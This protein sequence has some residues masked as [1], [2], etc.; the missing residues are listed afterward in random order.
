MVAA[1]LLPALPAAAEEPPTPD[2]VVTSEPTAEPT[3]DPTTEPTPESTP[4][5]DPTPTPTPTSTQPSDSTATVTYTG[6]AQQFS[7][8][9]I[10][11][12]T[13]VVQ[14]E[15][16]GQGF[17]TVDLSGIAKRV[18]ALNPVT[19][20][21]AVPAGLTLS[22][23]AAKRFTQ[24]ATASGQSPLVA[25]RTGKIKQPT[26][27]DATAQLVN[28]TPNVSATHH[29][30]AVY[31][32]PSNKPTKD[33]D[34]ATNGP[35]QDLVDYADQYWSKQSGGS[36]HFTLDGVVPWYK[37]DY[38]CKTQS[39]SAS[40]WSQALTKAKS[41]GY[42]PGRN[43][44]LV[45]IFPD[46]TSFNYTYCGGAI[47]LGTIGGSVNQGGQTWVMGTTD[48]IAFE[49]IAHELGH[50]MSL[51]HADWLACPSATPNTSIDAANLWTA[52]ARGS[53]DL[54]TK[55]N[56]G[57]I[58][59]VM[60][61][62]MGDGIGGPLSAPQAIRAGIWPSGSYIN[63]P[64]GT[65]TYTLTALSSYTGTRGIVVQD[66]DGTSYFLEMRNLAGDDAT[67]HQSCPSQYCHLSQPN[68]RMLRFEP[69]GY[70]G[71]PGEDSFLIGRSNT[72][73]G[74]TAAS[75]VYTLPK[76]NTVQINS[77]GSTTAS[78][79]VQRLAPSTEV[80]NDWV[81]LSRTLGYDSKLRVGD[82]LTLLIGDYYNLE[83]ADY[84]FVWT[85]D[86]SSSGMPTTQNYTLKPADVGHRINAYLLADGNQVF[87]L[88]GNGNPITTGY[89]ISKGI[90]QPSDPGPVT[91]NFTNT[92]FTVSTPLG[93]G[94]NW[95]NG[96]EFT[97]QWMRGATDTTATT[98]STGA[99]AT[100]TSYTPNA[101]DWNQFLRVKVTATVPGYEP[102]VRYSTPAINKSIYTQ[103]PLPVE[104]TIAG[105]PKIG[106][107]VSV[108]TST[109]AYFDFGGSSLSGVTLEYQWLRNGVPITDTP[110]TTLDA[111]DDAD[112]TLRSL[113]YNASIT[114]RVTASKNGYV[115]KIFSTA[116]FKPTQ[117][118]TIQTAGPAAAI[119]NSFDAAA[120]MKVALTASYTGVTEP[121]L[122]TPGY[123]WYRV[124]LTSGVATAISG[125]TGSVY[126]PVAGDYPYKIRVI[127][128]IKKKNYASLPLTYTHDFSI[129]IDPATPLGFIGNPRVDDLIGVTDPDM[130]VTLLNDVQNTVHFG[131]PGVSVL[132]QWRRSGVNIPNETDS[133]YEPVA[134]DV[135][136]SLSY[137][138]KIG[139]QG[140]IGFTA[141]SPNSDVTAQALFSH[142]QDV[143]LTGTGL[144]KTA[145][146]NAND[147]APYFPDTKITYQW[148]RDGANISGETKSTYLLTSADYGHSVKV[149][150]SYSRPGY[151]TFVQYGE[152]QTGKFWVRANPIRP[153]LTG[154]HTVGST[155]TFDPSSVTY[156]T[157]LNGATLSNPSDM[158]WAYQW[159][160]DG[161][162]IT[163]QISASYVVK[164]SD[165][166][167]T[168][169]LKVT[170]SSPTY[171][172]LLPSVSTSAAIAMVGTSELPG[173]ST[174]DP[175]LV[176]L[177]SSTASK[178]V[179]GFT[180]AVGDG[181][182][183]I[184]SP[185]GATNTVKYQWLRN[186]VAITGAT[187]STYTL[188]TS[189]RGK[190]I[191]LRITTSHAAIGPTSYT[192]D[193]RYSNEHDFS[194]LPDPVNPPRLYGGAWTVGTFIGLADVNF[195]DSSGTPV[196]PDAIKVEWLRTINGTTTL[197]STGT[198]QSYTLVAADYG[199]TMSARLTA[200]EP[201]FVPVTYTTATLN[202]TV[203]KGTDDDAWTPEVQDGPGLGQL[204]AA[205]TNLGPATPA[206]TLTY[207]WLR[208]G[209]AISGATGK[210]YT[211]VT[212]DATKDIS[213][214]VTMK[215]TNFE[216]LANPT[217]TSASAD[218]T[219][220]MDGGLPV[221]D[222]DGTPTVGE[223]ISA[224][225]PKF[226]SDSPPTVELTGL[227]YVYTWYRSGSV[228]TG[229]TTG[230]YTLTASDLNKVITVKV[231]AKLAG[232]LSATSPASSATPAVG[233]G[234]IVP[235]GYHPVVT[236]TGSTT[237]TAK[238]TFSGS[239]SVP[240]SGLTK[241]YKW[242]RNGSLISGQTA[243]SYKLVS[244]DKGKLITVVVTLKKSGFTS[245][246]LAPV[247]A[248]AILKGEDPVT[249][250]EGANASTA[251][252]GQLLSVVAPF[253]YL[254]DQYP[255]GTE[256]PGSANSFQWYSDGVAIPGATSVTYPL[257]GDQALGSVITV[258][259]TVVG[260]GY[261]QTLVDSSSNAITVN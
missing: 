216:P 179:I 92:P 237:K 227:T 123:Q 249:Q 70:S 55:H 67:A 210:T 35:A 142:N 204:T 248:N 218:H 98:K 182:T 260:G 154:S 209:S 231:T 159:Y 110:A 247:T 230:F 26:A 134:A 50:N 49:T 183:G 57:D 2:P 42:V 170:A 253:Y 52:S 191:S 229:A 149:K 158:D 131:S 236:L 254:Q 257:P 255:G 233:I 41:K 103:T 94:S 147:V 172:F 53:I 23:D 79:T 156:F 220:Y 176:V 171:P 250:V 225:P 240:T 124:G 203:G 29:V 44:H 137:T 90:Y 167:H 145:V 127:I 200:S 20:T 101:A 241:T 81:Y 33:P 205:V 64:L 173:V 13:N 196:N 9:G 47:G 17:L 108:N 259:I 76:G 87:E 180:S 5:A 1:S 37:S 148:L 198:D 121:E 192:T 116:P 78:V 28:Q 46:D 157:M 113:D 4:T 251:H 128:T 22:D 109:L 71:W 89:L 126:K 88:D 258:K 56:Y 10:D 238:V 252:P 177:G 184:T 18:D 226:Y 25:L 97:Y 100:T 256:L 84:T 3:A 143:A 73:I 188:T 152:N 155:L 164:T 224:D 122:G 243:S 175:T 38:S 112:Y 117:L 206:P 199:A 91:T 215:R 163:G 59:D 40:L 19:L 60:G 7:E 51:G 102:V 21:L 169:T 186:G 6:V 219:M 65:N 12:D 114:L 36:I 99:G 140:W 75:G 82:T 15:V 132:F 135:G 217:K 32:S 165:K 150:V 31:V 136:K 48:P 193:V 39:G 30:F 234:T 14:F 139:Y 166:G 62:G 222:Q 138:A 197:A 72:N 120:P 174:A 181:Q 187:K 54:C 246:P 160:R 74:W 168:I 178:T 106:T 195:V 153:V 141:T 34:T 45:L 85:R 63:A 95:P 146:A 228:I 213:V 69:T 77:V 58:A 239:P 83:A 223:M 43:M 93:G 24:L 144:L 133:T 242:Y 86:G 214:R 221:I 27:P 80:N 16:S 162:K 194:L 212:A 161:V 211:L 130:H 235:G 261:Y 185:G 105:T 61:F 68:V 119:T 232:Q 189:D 190:N 104:F 125:A 207:Q 244:A 115:S 208:D 107:Q 151:K 11:I 245:L 202:F 111:T 8:D 129:R 118:G 96:T 201:G 66:R